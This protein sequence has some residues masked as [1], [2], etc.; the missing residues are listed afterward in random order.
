ML[1]DGRPVE[2]TAL[3]EA[4]GQHRLRVA[5]HPAI[6]PGRETQLRLEAHLVPENWPPQDD[7]ITITLPEV[8][9]PQASVVE[10]SYLVKADSELDVVPEQIAGLDPAEVPIEGGRLGFVYQDTRFRG[11]L[12]VRRQ[13][14]RLS[15]TTVCLARLERD[16][17]F[18]HLEANLQVRG[19]GVAGLRVLLPEAVGRDL[20][21]ELV[22]TTVRLIEQQAGQARD[23]RRP[24]F[25][26]FDRR[27]TG[28]ATLTVEV[29]VP[30]TPGE[31]QPVAAVKPSTN[32]PEKPRPE[33]KRT[34]PDQTA[35]DGGDGNSRSSV[36]VPDLLLPDAEWQSGYV[37]IEAGDEQELT[38][39]A[40]DA[41]GRRL[42]T[43]DWVDFP[44]ARYQP[45]ERVV[46]AYRHAT[47]GYHVI[48][49]EKRYER[50]SLPIAVCHELQILSVLAPTG[51]IQ[52]EAQFRFSAAGVQSLAVRLPRSAS[53]WATRIDGQPVI[54]QVGKEGRY[55]VPLPTAAAPGSQHVL[56]VLYRTQTD[57]LTFAG[58][59]DQAPP[60]IEAISGDGQ[61]AGIE[62]LQTQW[63]LRYPPSTLL[64]KSEGPLRPTK[65]LD[66]PD[67]GQ[68]W[69]L[70][71]TLASRQQMAANLVGLAGVSLVLLVILLVRRGFGGCR[72]SLGAL[73]AMFAGVLVLVLL[74]LPAT[75][76]AREAAR[77]TAVRLADR[78]RVGATAAEAPSAG[79]MAAELV[80]ED[81][82]MLHESAEQ[83]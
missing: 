54:V 22:G 24:W 1:V 15:A 78:A 29:V 77:R 64:V 66:Q 67:W 44:R 79:P 71:F 27:L 33:T 53:L 58:R 72:M 49:R 25:L 75:E 82:R 69:Q 46:A 12:A 32:G 63:T 16:H 48:L 34:A 23:G 60:S 76:R 40:Q 56:A 45:V 35:E 59:F 2:W 14:T 20:R 31:G 62:V 19:G 51:R 52:N 74:L 73:L 36:I 9:L 57:P 7:P 43:V 80:V 83:L 39:D 5:F 70:R 42:D 13:P 50:S 38:I 41:A 4:A 28:T 61:V 17:L 6:P 3:T 11:K 81:E 55:L 68:R 21:F 47:G 65:P 37:A 26:R 10:G 8:R 18:A 30:R